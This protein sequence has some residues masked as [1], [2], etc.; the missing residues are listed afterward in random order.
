[1]HHSL[2]QR[3]WI[4]NARLVIRSIIRKCVKCLRFSAKQQVQ[5]LGILPS[6]RVT[7]SRPFLFCAVDYGGPF[8]IRHGGQKSS[9]LPKAYVSLFICLATRAIHLELVPDLTASAFIAAL[10]RFMAR[11]GIPSQLYLSLIH[12]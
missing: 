8:M 12:I 9:T 3:W 4:V 1:M 5:R 6:P 2:R 10:R 7:P 11:R